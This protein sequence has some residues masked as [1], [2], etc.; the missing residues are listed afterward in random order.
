MRRE[1]WETA[2]RDISAPGCEPSNAFESFGNRAGGPS[3]PRTSF[4]NRCS[5]T[6]DDQ[7]ELCIHV[8]DRRKQLGTIFFTKHKEK[9]YLVYYNFIVTAHLL[10]L[11]ATDG[12]DHLLRLLT[13]DD[14]DHLPHLWAQMAI[15]PISVSWERSTLDAVKTAAATSLADKGTTS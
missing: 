7:G 6:S 4:K 2:T 1:I 5:V 14:K 12:R 15:R 8:N 11:M 9:L 10:R 3:E 13:V